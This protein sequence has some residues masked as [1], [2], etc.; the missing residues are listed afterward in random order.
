MSTLYWPNNRSMKAPINT[1]CRPTID[2]KARQSI[3][4]T[5]SDRPPIGIGSYRLPINLE[6][7]VQGEK[8]KEKGKKGKESTKKEQ[9]KNEAEEKKKETK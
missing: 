6:P 4:I 7:I 9:R 3:P 8:A 2:F 1:Y 5:S